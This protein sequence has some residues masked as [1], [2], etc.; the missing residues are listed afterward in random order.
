MTNIKDTKENKDPLWGGKRN[1]RKKTLPNVPR[2]TWPKELVEREFSPAN[3]NLERERTAAIP[4][5]SDPADRDS[6]SPAW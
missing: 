1:V 5:P 6:E 4:T 3:V 2:V